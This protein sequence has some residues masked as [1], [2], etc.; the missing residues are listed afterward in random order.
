LWFREAPVVQWEKMCE[1]PIYM[2]IMRANKPPMFTSPFDSGPIKL[3][4]DE[5]LLRLAEDAGPTSTAASM[6]RE[7]RA[8]RAKDR[9]YFAFHVNEYF[10]IGPVPG[11]AT[12]ADLLA[13]ADLLEVAP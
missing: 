1:S 7:L 13:L 3:V 6:L 11:S 10:F 5:E 4:P 9:Q 8:S 12:E 2:K